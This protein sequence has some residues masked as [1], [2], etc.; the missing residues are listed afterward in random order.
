MTRVN[1]PQCHRVLD[2]LPG[3]EQIYSKCPACETEFVPARVSGQSSHSIPELPP[4]LP[5]TSLSLKR[6]LLKG[7]K[8]T[9]ALMSEEQWKQAKRTFF[10]VVIALGGIA[11]LGRVFDVFFMDFVIIPVLAIPITLICFLL[12]TM[13]YL[14]PSDSSLPKTRWLVWPFVIGC[15]VGLGAVWLWTLQTENINFA[16][17]IVS[18]IVAAPIFGVLFTIAAAWALIFYQFL[19]FVSRKI[20]KASKLDDDDVRSAQDKNSESQS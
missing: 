20:E 3:Q 18:S 14:A 1:C 5:P 2:V 4:E 19:R 15:L 6:R 13:T 8:T 12:N 10:V 9:T 17:A 16:Q 7:T 11:V